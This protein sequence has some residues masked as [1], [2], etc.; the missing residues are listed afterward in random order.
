MSQP[1]LTDTDRRSGQ[2]V[3]FTRP[4]KY[5]LYNWLES[6]VVNNTRTCNAD[7][8]RRG[9]GWCLTSLGLRVKKAWTIKAK[10]WPDKLLSFLSN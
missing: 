9:L 8:G 7:W 1:A 5:A 6:T 3:L 4:Q 2:G 10:G